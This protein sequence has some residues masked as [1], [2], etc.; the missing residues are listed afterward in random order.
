MNVFFI[1]CPLVNQ[2]HRGTNDNKRNIKA[3]MCSTTEREAAITSVFSRPI[4]TLAGWF[5]PEKMIR[6]TLKLISC[7]FNRKR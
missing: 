3:F 1:S 5:W 7:T 4:H 6:V 2:Q